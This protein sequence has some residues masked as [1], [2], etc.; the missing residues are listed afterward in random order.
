MEIIL[1]TGLILGLTSNFHCI[2]MCGPIAFVLPVERSSKSKLIF[3]TFLK[4]SNAIL[5]R[6]KSAKNHYLVPNELLEA[7]QTLK[8]IHYSENKVKTINN[9]EFYLASLIGRK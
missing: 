9:I 7:F 1:L 6:K 3:Q 8:V 4:P 2:G 5:E